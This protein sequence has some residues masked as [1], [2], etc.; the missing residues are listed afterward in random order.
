MSFSTEKVST[1]REGP[2]FAE[3]AYFSGEDMS[4]HGEKLRLRTGGAHFHV[5]M[6]YFNG[7]DPFPQR[8]YFVTGRKYLFARKRGG[9]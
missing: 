3:D 9:P 1:T 7:D 2:Y 8:S 4:F 5:V 6:S